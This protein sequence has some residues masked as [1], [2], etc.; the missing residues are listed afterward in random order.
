MLIP[1]RRVVPIYSVSYKARKWMTYLEWEKL[2]YETLPGATGSEAEPMWTKMLLR[3]NPRR[4]RDQ[5]N[6]VST[7]TPT[8][9]MCCDVEFPPVDVTQSFFYRGGSI[10]DIYSRRQGFQSNGESLVIHNGN[11]YGNQRV[12]SWGAVG[13]RTAPALV[14]PPV[15]RVVLS[16]HEGHLDVVVRR[17]VGGKQAA[18]LPNG[19]VCDLLQTQGENCQI[20]EPDS[21]VTGWVKLQNTLPFP[22]THAVVGPDTIA[23]SD[24]PLTP[25][26]EP[27]TPTLVRL[28][29]AGAA[30]P[31]EKPL[32]LTGAE[33]AEQEGKKKFDAEATVEEMRKRGAYYSPVVTGYRKDTEY[34]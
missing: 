9:E 29:G 31:L 23:I 14:A 30:N 7:S 17:Q 33:E 3:G 34:L 5:D 8:I 32:Y 6:T 12:L 18:N 20:H 26:C 16:Q 27:G 13:P 28:P 15:A 25:T 11:R 24:Q 19:T 10:L 2:I 1:P 4:Q 21:K 22:P